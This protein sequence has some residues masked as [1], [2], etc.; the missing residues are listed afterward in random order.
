M[1]NGP[2]RII[3]ADGEVYE[4]QFRNDK[5]HGFGIYLFADGSRYEGEW[6][7]DE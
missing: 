7:E 6:Y 2:G 3:H 5:S 4:G 1:A